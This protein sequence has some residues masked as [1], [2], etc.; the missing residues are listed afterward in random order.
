VTQQDRINEY[1]TWRAPSYDADQEHN[2]RVVWGGIWS[3]A[4]PGNL[5]VLD[6]GT[7]SGFVA[8]LLAAAGHRVTGVD[9]SE[10]MLDRARVHGG[11]A[12]FRLGD[13]MDPPFPAGSF[14]AVVN[15]YVL[16]TLGDPRR[17]VRNWRRLLRPGGRLAVVDGS[18][19]P[20]G[21]TTG[22]G[23][24]FTAGY[25]GAELPLASGSPDLLREL[26]QAEG[27]T[28]VRSEALTDLF[29]HDQRHGVSPG[30]RPTLQHLTSARA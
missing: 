25:S 17:A 18:W 2:D 14:D 30:H 13:A 28:D 10:G 21:L 16:W 12:E 11:P 5:D 29:E 3:R 19:F 8:R 22:S 6:V 20:N 7:G 24:E 27:F 23:A 1:W 26:L 4:L 15:R 9:L